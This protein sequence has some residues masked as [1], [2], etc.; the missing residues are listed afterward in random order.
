V[1]AHRTRVLNNKR[2]SG[3]MLCN[4]LHNKMWSNMLH[5]LRSSKWRAKWRARMARHT[6]ESNCPPPPPLHLELFRLEQR[7]RSRVASPLLRCT[8]GDNR[9]QRR[10][11]SR[12]SASRRGCAYGCAAGLGGS[13]R[14]RGRR[15]CSEGSASRSRRRSCRACCEWRL[16]WLAG[17][18]VF[19]RALQRARASARRWACHRLSGHH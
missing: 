5:T 9:R 14:A 3:N 16:A 7:R 12:C 2:G 11:Q 8:N 17:S 10:R 18:L 1:G 15:P 13:P 4:M 6:L 19:V